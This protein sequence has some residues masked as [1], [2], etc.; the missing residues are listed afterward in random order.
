MVS[1]A[2]IA[3]IDAIAQALDPEVAIQSALDTFGERGHPLNEY[4]L[5]KVNLTVNTKLP[6]CLNKFLRRSE[7]QIC[8]SRLTVHRFFILI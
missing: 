8:T 5:S 1:E 3:R 2:D 4:L 7:S 6:A